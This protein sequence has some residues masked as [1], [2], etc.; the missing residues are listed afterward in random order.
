MT[1]GT[2][3][4]GGMLVSILGFAYLRHKGLLLPD[5]NQGVQWLIMYPFCM[6][7]S[8]ASD[9]DHH[10]D[11]IPVRDYPSRA[12]NTVLHLAEKPFKA[13]DEKLTDKQKKTNIL[14]NLCGVFYARHRSW[15]THSDL[16]LFVILWL[17]YMVTS[18]KVSQFGAIDVAV[19]SLVLTGISMGIIAHFIL[20]ILTPDGVYCFLWTLFR[21]V[22]MKLFP[23][24]KLYKRFHLVPHKEYF[25]TGGAWEA[26][27]RKFLGL[28][29]KLALLWIV[30]V[31][32]RPYIPFEI[33]FN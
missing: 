10:K 33:S 1:G 2:H 3:R 30:W 9:L 8:V 31:F 29:T 11:A 25:A 20:D 24:V 7:G 6:W 14:Y 21:A 26:H 5:V 17:L 19:T 13:L 18:G 28:T 32:V 27:V 15:Q 16:T 4:A 22:V 23:K 12:I